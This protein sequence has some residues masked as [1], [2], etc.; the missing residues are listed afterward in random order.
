M[1]LNILIICQYGAS[2]CLL[3]E[4]MKEIVSKK[5]LDI[6][7][8]AISELNP[9]KFVA[10]ADVILVAPQLRYKYQEFLEVYGNHNIPIL[11]IDPGDYGNMDGLKILEL[12]LNKISQSSQATNKG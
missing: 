12:A 3:Q 6:T 2:S 9:D 1:G 5:G 7:L 4:Q 8:H 10:Q 11:N